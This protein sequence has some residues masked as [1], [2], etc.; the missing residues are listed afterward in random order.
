M[1]KIVIFF[2]LKGAS[3]IR[4]LE[5]FLGDEEFKN[6]ITSFLN[7]FKFANAVTQD[8]WNELQ[9]VGKDVNITH[10]MDTWTRQMGYPVVT[11]TRG[12][13]GAITLEQ[14]RFLSDP[15]ANTTNSSP[16]GWVMTVII[17]IGSVTESVSHCYT[18]QWSQFSYTVSSYHR[19]IQSVTKIEIRDYMCSSTRTL[20][21]GS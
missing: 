14:K 20:S 9:V 12:Q 8:L 1:S 15:D 5:D 13:N 6:G 11:V 7:H 2:V 18:S 17:I 21:N 19:P 3:V 16:Y 10:V 4:M